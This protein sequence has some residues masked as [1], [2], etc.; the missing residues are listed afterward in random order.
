MAK[1]YKDIY[2][3]T[4]VAVSLEQRYYLKQE[5]TRGELIAPTGSDF[6]YT[7]AGGSVEFTQPFISSPH[8]SGR[9]NNNAIQQK[10]ECS[11][12]IPT[13]FN[14]DTTLGAASAA[15]IDTPVKAL[16]KSL[17]GNEDLS[18][19][20]KYLVSTPSTTFS[21]M[22][23]GDKWARQVRGGFV[24]SA[25]MNFPGDGEANMEWTGNA[26]DA[27]YVGM[28]KSTVS[29]DGGNTITLEAGDGSQFL[30]STDGYVM[31]IEADGVTRSADTPDG[32]PRKITQVVGDVITVDGAVLAD[33]DGSGIGAPIYFVYYEPATPVG[34]D[35]PVTGLTGTM[36]VASI[37]AICARNVTISLGNEHELINYCYG[38]DSLAGQMFVPGGRFMATVEVEAN[39]DKATFKLFQQLQNFESQSLTLV[40]GEAAGRRLEVEIPRGIFEVPSVSVP[41]T[42][43]IPVTFSGTAYQ[44]ALDA[45]DEIS[46]HFT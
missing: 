31:I 44:T 17:M 18:A 39:L 30:K 16:W 22:E 6:L 15:E 20:A 29:N 35:N 4:N 37:G 2:E 5:T 34:I 10:K 42:G 11:W 13:Y 43:S 1:N 21:L 26:K 25:T 38:E 8:R 19:G 9:H 3:S 24:Q 36:N 28:G 45:A 27:I 32:S 14:I 40:L 41:E 7:L 23:T 33:A 46:V 12:T